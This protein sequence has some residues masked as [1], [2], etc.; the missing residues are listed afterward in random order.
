MR[1]PH[2]KKGI[3]KTGKPLETTK[4]PLEKTEKPLKKTG[5]PFVRTRKSL[6]KTG[7]PLE[8]TKT[9]FQKTEDEKTFRNPVEIVTQWKNIEKVNINQLKFKT[10]GFWW[11]ILEDLKI[12]L[13]ISREHEHLMVC[14]GS[15]DHKAHMSYMTIPHPSG[16]AVDR[17]RKAVF[18]A[19]TRNPNQ[20]YTFYPLRGCID[21]I[22]NNQSKKHLHNK[23]N[24]LIPTKVL[25]Y[26]GSLYLHDL[27]FIEN[28]LY[29]NAVGHNTVVYLPALGGYRNVW[30]PTGFGQDK[31][32]HG[33]GSV[34][35]EI[36]KFW[37]GCQ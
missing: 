19:S 21:R 9:G 29:A 31:R 16:I 1:Q 28:N 3:E 14:L 6:D 4:K 2:H 12:Q 18:I 7:K 32:N 24:P 11:D 36:E 20:V 23:S 22:E 27:S 13:L 15:K 17:K 25:F 33:F 34:G 35:G 5:R 37:L 10:D 30:W 8:K 26:P